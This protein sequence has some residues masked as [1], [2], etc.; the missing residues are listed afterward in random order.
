MQIPAERLDQIANRFAEIEA[1]MA[2]GTLE[3]D[4]FVQASRDYAELEPVAKIAAEVKAAREEIAGLEHML[5]D[6][7][8]K[9]MAEEELAAI[10]DRL[11]EAERQLAVAMLPKDSADSKPAML[12]I[13]AGTGGDEAALFAGDLYR[14]YEKF[15]A[16]QGWKVEPVSMSAS[17]VGGFKEVVANIRGTGV[18]AKLKF[19]SGVHRVQ[20]VPVTESG[21]RIHT[22]AA[23]VAVLPEPDE[24]DITID[25]SD[26]K[27]D[28][29]RASGA[30]GQHVNTT[31]S[32]IRITHLPTDTVVTC[33]DGRSQH[34]NRE[35]AMKVLR[36]RLFET[37]RDEAQGA[38]AEAR[39][40]MV[41]SGDRSERIRTYN[42][43]QGRVTDHRIGLTLHKLPEVLEGSGLT[44]LIDALIAED[45]A[46]R[47]A[48]LNE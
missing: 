45:E 21:G 43:P 16:E 29:Y 27:I 36:A 34:K 2:S 12:E 23:T 32:A 22:S 42:F 41:G 14:M 20:R 24:V 7:E 35:Q 48:A 25:P 8:M 38:E 39:K 26:L 17:E 3:G 31:D 40:A 46:K 15:A 44:E 47:L 6:P 1:R 30:G 9:A 37:Q 10:R 4:A 33:Q 11:P 19:E 28:T 13:R 18:F 5:A